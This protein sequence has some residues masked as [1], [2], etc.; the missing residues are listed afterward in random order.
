ML[1]GAGEAAPGK[2]VWHSMAVI[3]SSA[4]RYNRGCMIKVIQ[5]HNFPPDYVSS[6][7]I[8]SSNGHIGPFSCFPPPFV[9]GEKAPI[10]RQ[11]ML[12][13][14]LLSVALPVVDVLPP[15]AVSQ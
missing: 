7:V 14:N 2:E 5:D 12:L 11:C 15:A 13:T 6:A 4:L 3:S 8:V 9:A 1:S 10:E